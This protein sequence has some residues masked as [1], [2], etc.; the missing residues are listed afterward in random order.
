MQPEKVT[1]VREWFQKATNDLRGA[2]IDLAALPP[3]IEDAL[4]HC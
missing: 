2:N 1:E 3:L 4:F